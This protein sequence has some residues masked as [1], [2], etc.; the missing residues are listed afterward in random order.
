MS[1][2]SLIHK[3]KTFLF[4]RSDTGVEKNSHQSSSRSINIDIFVH[5]F[6]IDM[7]SMLFL[8]L[9]LISQTIVNGILKFQTK[10][11]KDALKKCCWHKR[12]RHL[13]FFINPFG[14]QYVLVCWSHH[15]QISM[16]ANTLLLKERIGRFLLSLHH[17]KTHPPQ[18]FPLKYLSGSGWIS[19]MDLKMS[20]EAEIRRLAELSHPWLQC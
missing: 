2:N 19:E 11:M 7:M 3:K 1:S 20:P 5:S 6:E 8:K 18:F 14:W 17:Q 4:L 15:L 10:G 12:Q 9:A 13:H 16:M